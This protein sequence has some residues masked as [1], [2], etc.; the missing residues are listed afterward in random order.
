[1]VCNLIFDKEGKT[2]DFIDII[3]L[4][5]RYVAAL[6]S[7]CTQEP[8]LCLVH[9]QGSVNICW[10]NKWVPEGWVELIWSLIFIFSGIFIPFY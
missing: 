5:I 6:L 4:L 1:M 10:Q 9:S 7:L 8:A 2:M 3:D